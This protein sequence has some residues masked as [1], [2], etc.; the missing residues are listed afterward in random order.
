M[1]AKQQLLKFKAFAC[2]TLVILLGTASAWCGG[3]FVPTGVIEMIPTSMSD[4]ASTVVGTGFLGVPNLYY[5]PAAGAS[6]I[7][8]GCFNGLPAISGDGST[9]VGC[10]VDGNGY[11]NAAKWLGGT[12]WLDLGSEPGAVPCGTSLSGAYGISGDGSIAAGLLW[13]AQVCK[14]N[15]GMWDLVNGGPAEVLPSLI[16]GPASRANAVNGDGSVIVGWQDQLNGERSAAKWV[17]L[18][19]EFILANDGS[20]NGEAMAVNSDGSAIVGGGYRFGPEAWIWRAATGVQPIGTTGGVDKGFFTA[21][22]VSENGQIAVGFSRKGN[23]TRAFIWREGRGTTFLDKYLASRG[24]V[25]PEGWSLRAASLISADGKTIY[26]WGIN[27]D[28]LIE[29]YRVD[30]HL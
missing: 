22:D 11:E 16:N 2:G 17:D 14:A 7:G 28:G 27:P 1:K 6:V 25:I 23:R 5:T 9:L 30:L 24:I 3:A 10:H 21:L 15:A 8:D 13:R 20:L 18:V 12:S 19:P 4:D 29:M 26:G